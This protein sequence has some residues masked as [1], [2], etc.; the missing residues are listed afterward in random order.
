MKISTGV[1]QLKLCQT[2]RKRRPHYLFT[3]FDRHFL[4]CAEANK[5]SCDM[6]FV[7]SLT[8]NISVWGGHNIF[9]PNF[10]SLPE[11]S[12]MFGQ[13]ISA[14]HGGGGG[15][16]SAFGVI[17]YGTP[18]RGKVWEGVS[19]SHDG[20]FFIFEIWVLKTRFW[21]HYKF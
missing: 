10:S 18:P 1:L 19:P 6:Q 21:V 13:C 9:C 4:I 2:A 16:S 14:S 8:T 12:N 7:Y 15:G 3:H 5:V 11:K 20:D 17:E